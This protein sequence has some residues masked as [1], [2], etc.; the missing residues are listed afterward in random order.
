MR[1]KI[2]L[3]LIFTGL[4]LEWG[5]QV[6]G[7]AFGGLGIRPA[8]SDPVNPVTESWFIYNLLP[9]ESRQDGVIISN[10]SDKVLMGKIYPVDATT[11]VDGAF[12]LRGENEQRDDVGSWVSLEKDR[13]RVAPE[14]EEEV[15][16][17]ISIPEG[18]VVGDH[19]GGIVLENLEMGKGKGVNVITRVGARIYQTVPGDLMKRLV[20]KDFSWELVEDKPIFYFDLENQ[21]NVHL[22]PKAVLKIKEGFLGT[23]VFESSFDLRMVLPEKPTR[24]P[25]VW[26]EGWPLGK[27]VAEVGIVYGDQ[28]GERIEREISFWYVGRAVRRIVF[29][30]GGGVLLVVAFRLLF[31]RRK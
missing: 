26:K 21:G 4:W 9:G 12:A 7:A 27:F 28:P 3:V 15:L 19:L 13:V 18:A 22:D 20:L 24:V 1:F 23:K 11:T 30:L 16:F 10:T 5:G 25:I 2:I 29:V 6:Y 31:I 17:T 14:S 8:N